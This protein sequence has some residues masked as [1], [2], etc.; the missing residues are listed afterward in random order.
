MNKVLRIICLTGIFIIPFV[1]LLVAD[2]LFFPFISG[3][4]FAFRIIV[5]IIFGAWVVL[6]LTDKTYRPRKSFI[7]WAL[8][9]FIVIIGLADIFGMNPFKSFWSNFERMEG[10]VGLVHLGLYML[11]AAT[12]LNTTKLWAWFFNTTIGASILMSLY[13]YGQLFKWVTINQGGGR[14]DARLGNAT[15]LAVY[16]LFHIFLT[17]YLMISRTMFLATPQD[18]KPRSTKFIIGG[19]IILLEFVILYYTAT[20]GAMLGLIGGV[21]LSA[22]LIVIFGK[23]HPRVRKVSLGILIA[24][25]V[26]IGGFLGLKDSSFVRQSP[27]LNRF[28]TISLNDATTNSR[29][30]L[31]NMAIEGF[32]ERPILGWGQE[33]FNYVFNKYYNPV[34]YN[35]EQW[36]DRTHNVIFDWLI[37]GGIL[38]LV[39]Y[40]SLYGTIIWSIWRTKDTFTIIEKSI[41]TG[42]LGGYFIHNLFVFDNLTSYI[43]FFTVAAYI[44]ART[45]PALVDTPKPQENRFALPVV[46]VAALLVLYIVNIKPI[47]AGTG[48]IDA[49]TPNANA[50]ASQTAPYNG[51][52]TQNLADFKRIIGYNTFAT[53]EAREQIMNM[54]Q[55]AA[56]SQTPVTGAPEMLQYAV[57]QGEAQLQATPFD[58]RHYAIYGAFLSR[59]GQFDE[60]IEKFHKA[61]ELSPRKQSLLY[62]LGAAYAAKND[63]A[64]A[65]KYFK[66]AYDVYPSNEQA[67]ILYGASTI[68]EGKNTEAAEI[69][70]TVA[71]STLIQN[72]YILQAYYNTK[73]YQ[74]VLDTWKARVALD[75]LN[76]QI[77][78]S[79]TAAYLLLNDKANAIAEI[80]KVIGMEPSFKVQGEAYI[81]QIQEGKAL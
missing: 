25:L 13:G 81:K 54:A 29:F 40:L 32:K 73:Q 35:Q 80:R 6:A 18:P 75:P 1:P 79:L 62:E 68:Y 47:L 3:K 9:A 21:L 65:T 16:I 44:Y 58:A 7:L 24:T 41:L 77:H 59:I 76:P 49:L 23:A 17:T 20:R 48:L 38:G 72:D 66:E 74:K 64:S 63:Y 37:A 57:E 67:R 26:V 19:V 8:G 10:F 43:L 56:V 14:L 60:S 55:Q 22:A 61:V 46:I 4:N 28:A 11:V 33:N 78:L 31:W 50:A 45:K 36:F 52:I 15:Y 53:T 69:L 30:V 42:M 27:V 39:S 51:N 34:L 71:T 70:K 5:E 12:V 2:T